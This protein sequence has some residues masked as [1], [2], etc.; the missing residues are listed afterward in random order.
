MVD[1]QFDI[2]LTGDSPEAGALLDPLEIRMLL[3]STQH[4]IAQ[5][6]QNRLDGQTCDVHGEAPRVIVT[7]AYDLDTE[8]MDVQYNIEACCNLMIMKSAAL[9]G[10]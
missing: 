3:E 7:G 8:Q 6:V 2:T 9:L 5:H 1:V 4:H 10:R